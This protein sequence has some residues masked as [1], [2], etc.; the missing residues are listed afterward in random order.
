MPA[1]TIIKHLN[2]AKLW[3]DGAMNKYGQGNN[4]AAYWDMTCAENELKLAK[5][6]ELAEN[7]DKEEEEKPSNVVPFPGAWRTTA[8][9][10]SGVA[11]CLALSFGL[12]YNSDYSL[13]LLT[14]EEVVIPE[15]E[16]WV[17]T[18]PAP[19]N[20]TRVFIAQPRK[21]EPK[22]EGS[23]APTKAE[24]RLP[25]V[26]EPREAA[27]KTQEIAPPARKK[28]VP[29]TQNKK[30]TKPT[31][32]KSSVAPRKASS[33]MKRLPVTTPVK[34]APV[35]AREAIREVPPPVPAVKETTA[36]VVPV[37]PAAKPKPK[38]K[39]D[40]LELLSEAEKSLN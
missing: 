26:E 15:D 21:G 10:A 9:V 20:I 37:V 38:P 31:P 27:P 5:R 23:M 29:E 6:M 36:E 22:S 32:Q 33:V 18:V 28:E 11:A 2:A 19:K 4:H 40:V 17:T 34:V 39:V 13:R 35:P 12:L 8:K 30:R 7:S 24:E 1:E 25:E 16:K 14:P 3:I